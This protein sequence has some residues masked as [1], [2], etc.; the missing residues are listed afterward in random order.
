VLARLHE[1]TGEARW[2]ER[3]EALIR[4]FAGR[5]AELGL[6]AAA[7][8]L[9]VD[10]HHSPTT[11]L[12]IV[13]QP[14]DPVADQMHADAL[15]GFVPR[16][17]VRRL[18]PSEASSRPLPPAMAGMLAAGQAPRGYA[19]TGLSCRAPAETVEQWHA[20]LAELRSD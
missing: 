20:T 9:A 3:G 18:A 17:V 19:C 13:G 16:R 10:W 2:R 11:Q 6:Y 8:L 5:A 7:Y 4:A 12:V 15:S 1:H 14:G